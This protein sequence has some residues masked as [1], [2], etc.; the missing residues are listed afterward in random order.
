M[1]FLYLTIFFFLSFNSY[2]STK[3]EIKNKLNDTDNMYFK[4][5]QKIDSKTEKGECR[6]YYPKKILCKYEDIFEKILVSN[7]RSLVINSKK[8]KNY[9]NYKLKDTPLNI[10]LDKDFLLKKIDEVDRVEQNNET[11]FFK[12]EYDSNLISI[13]FDKET[14]DIIGWTTVD[15]YQNKVETKLFNVETNIMIDK[16]IFKLQKYIN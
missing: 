1:K 13:F 15:I 8:I 9:L 16:S 12:V 6:I 10:I 5:V 2:A 3:N 14:Y 4:F 7:G 11:Y